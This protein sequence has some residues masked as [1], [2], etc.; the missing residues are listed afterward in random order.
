MSPYGL[1]AQGEVS[2]PLRFSGNFS[3]TETAGNIVITTGKA[4]V[5]ALEQGCAELREKNKGKPE[6]PAIIS[7]A[8]DEA[9]LLFLNT[10]AVPTLLFRTDL[11][12]IK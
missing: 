6:L 12:S 9:G 4:G 11:I 7:L 8:Q 2:S 1:V 10:V 5:L 3:I